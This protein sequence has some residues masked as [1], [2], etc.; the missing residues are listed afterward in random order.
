[1]KKSID[2]GNVFAILVYSGAGL[3]DFM[4][5]INTLYARKKGEYDRQTNLKRLDVSKQT[6]AYLKKS[7]PSRY[8]DIKRI[9]KV[10]NDVSRGKVFSQWVQANN[11]AVEAAV[12]KSFDDYCHK[13]PPKSMEDAIRMVLLYSHVKKIVSGGDL[14][15]QDEDEKSLLL[16]GGIEMLLDT[17]EQTLESEFG[18]GTKIKALSKIFSKEHTRSLSAF[19]DSPMMFNSFCKSEGRYTEMM[20]IA[21]L[22][23]VKSDEMNVCKISAR[24]MEY[25]IKLGV[26]TFAEAHDIDIDEQGEE[27]LRKI[28]DK[29]NFKEL[30]KTIFDCYML[31]KVFGSYAAVR[32][33]AIELQDE[34]DKL[35]LQLEE[36]KKERKESRK[37]EKSQPTMNIGKKSRERIET[38]EKYVSARQEKL[39]EMQIS[40]DKLRLENQDMKARLEAAEEMLDAMRHQLEI[41]E[42]EAE[43]ETEEQEEKYPEGTVLFGGYERW[44]KFF[45]K[46]H[47]EIGNVISGN[48][49][50]FN[51]GV[52]N[53]KTPLCLVNVSH[54]C[55]PAYWK[56]RGVLKKHNVRWKFIYPRYRGSNGNLVDK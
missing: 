51:T 37:A 9:L 1:M 43:Q 5:W 53:K 16:K 2:Y 50:S 56:L 38:L 25:I 42:T 35:K 44:Q 45:V 22:M 19:A 46:H 20:Y 48:N 30:M 12:A 33:K 28:T 31:V 49:A 29:S 7:S 27:A 17:R 18:P 10:A 8:R 3:P 15:L 13:C 54:A 36:E 23:G 32:D 6:L 11:D 24:R 21:K 41:D 26:N 4:S 55:H 34:N 52:I 39:N 14:N 47:P 40:Y